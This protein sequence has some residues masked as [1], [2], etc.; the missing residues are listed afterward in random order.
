MLE[1]AP[2]I[3]EACL[4]VGDELVDCISRNI[5]HSVVHGPVE[6][7]LVPDLPVFHP[8]ALRLAVSDYGRRVGGIRRTVL[9]IIVD[10]GD[11]D[12]WFGPHR[13]AVGDERVDLRIT[14]GIGAVGARALLRVVVVAARPEDIE[15]EG[16]HE[17]LGF[18]HVVAVAVPAPVILAEQSRHRLACRPVDGDGP[19]RSVGIGRRESRGRGRGAGDEDR[20]RETRRGEKGKNRSDWTHENLLQHMTEHRRFR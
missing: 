5:G 20:R 4:E 19:R 9:L 8:I 6:V 2:F 14:E 3:A 13:L 11:L 1:S 15:L 17:G 12:E 7:G 16:R 18:R 10:Q